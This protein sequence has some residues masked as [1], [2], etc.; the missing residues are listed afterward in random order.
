MGKATSLT[1]TGITAFVLLIA[2]CASFE[3]V[4]TGYRAVGTKFGKVTGDVLEPGFHVVNPIKDWDHFNT[5]RRTAAFDQVQVPAKDQQKA[6]MDVSIQYRITDNAVLNL[7][8]TTG[9]EDQVLT[10]HFVPNVRG[11]LRDAGRSTEKVEHF[12]QEATIEAYRSTALGALQSLLEPVGLEV[13]DVI[14][15]DVSLPSIIAKAIEAKKQREQEVERERA[16][17]NRVELEAQQQ[18]KKAAANLES[19][20]LDAQAVMVKADAEAYAI[21][22]VTAQLNPAYVDYVRAQRWNG[23]LPRFTG[24]GVIPFLDVTEATE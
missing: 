19:S 10:V 21:D 8:K 9:V 14:I 22:K 6:M 12:Y 2:G 18:V 13:T 1:I 11:T 16:E 4:S 17:L 5:L 24:G 23:L 7:R 20:K 3:T 15:R